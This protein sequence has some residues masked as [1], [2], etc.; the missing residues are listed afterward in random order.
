MTLAN[1]R[2][3][4]ANGWCVLSVTDGHRWVDYSAV[5]RLQSAVELMHYRPIDC[6]PISCRLINAA[7]CDY[8][9]HHRGHKHVTSF[10]KGVL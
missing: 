9:N 1:C 3:T 6:G 8:N 10:W 5:D 4:L 2:T 7:E